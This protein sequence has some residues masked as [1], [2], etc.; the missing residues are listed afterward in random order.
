[1]AQLSVLMFTS[2]LMAVLRGQAS[3]FSSH[4]MTPALLSS[5][6][7]ATTGRDAPSRFVRIVSPTL[8]QDLEA[9]A[10]LEEHVAVLEVDSAEVEVVDL[11]PV[12]DLE[13]DSAEVVVVMEADS[14]V[15][16]LAAEDLRRVL[17]QPLQHQTPLPISLRPVRTGAR[18]FTFV[19]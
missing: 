11:E 1:M 10:V 7:M 17:Q 2:D 18:L 12:V 9:E 14:E 16:H 4:L 8:V 19:M 13:A 3:L 5:N 15:V 6:S